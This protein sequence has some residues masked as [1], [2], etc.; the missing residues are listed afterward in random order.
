MAWTTF[1]VGP[2]RGDQGGGPGCGPPPAGSLQ[3]CRGLVL[4]PDRDPLAAL[5]LLERL[6]CRPE[7]VVLH[8]ELQMA[9]EC[10]V[11]AL[12]VQCVAHLALVGAARLGDTGGEDLPRVPRGRG[13]GLEGGVRQL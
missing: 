7:V 1:M 3:R 2:P 6:G 4:G 9:A 11:R 5:D 8:V 12:L 10:G 13:L